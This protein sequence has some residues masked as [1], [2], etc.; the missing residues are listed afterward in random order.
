MFYY[1]H[2]KCSI[3][4]RNNDMHEIEEQTQI[5]NIFWKVGNEDDPKIVIK[6]IQIDFILTW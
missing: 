1:K 5:Q 2:L 4:Q 6:S 3:G